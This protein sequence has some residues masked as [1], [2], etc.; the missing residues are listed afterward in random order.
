MNETISEPR[1][2]ISE[3]AP[4]LLFTK[5]NPEKIGAVIGS[6]GKTIQALAERI[7]G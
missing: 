7:S 4:S 1:T 2:T 3:L 6:G 5:I